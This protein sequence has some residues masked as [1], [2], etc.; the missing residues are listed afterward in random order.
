MVRR[1]LL[2]A[3]LAVAVFWTIVLGAQLQTSVSEVDA[4][5]K[6]K[7]EGLQ[8]SQV[9]DIASSITDGFGPRLTGS[10]NIK[11]AAQWTTKKMSEWGLANV[12][13]ETWGPFGRGW[14]NEHFYAAMVKPYPFPL[15][16]YTK[17]WTPGTNGTIKGDAIMA[18]VNTAAD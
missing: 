16:G 1:Q 15:I 10:P 12:K 17:A 5:A 3:G 2:V 8:H 11:A 6:I 14:T 9:M 7:E 13:L 18:I 4:I